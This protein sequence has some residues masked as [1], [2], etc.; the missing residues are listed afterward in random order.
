MLLVGRSVGQSVGA[1]VVGSVDVVD[2]AA[3]MLLPLWLDWLVGLSVGLS[4]LIGWLVDWFVNL[5]A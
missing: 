1:D 3:V 5:F 2:V 4:R